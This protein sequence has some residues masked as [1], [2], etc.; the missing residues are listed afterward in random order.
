VLA[1]AEAINELGLL[2]RETPNA[3]VGIDGQ[4]E[5]VDSQGNCEGRLLAV[6]VKSGPSYLT[7]E[8]SDIVFTVNPK[9][10]GYWERFPLPVM[11][12][13][14]DPKEDRTYWVDARHALRANP[15]SKTI[16][17]P[18]ANHLETT[19]IH[20]LFKTAGPVTGGYL[21]IQE[22]AGYMASKRHPDSGFNISFLELFGLGLT[23]VGRQLFFSMAL[24]M[25]IAEHHA[26]GKN[27][28]VGVGAPEYQFLKDYIDFLAAQDLARLDYCAILIDWDTRELVP[29]FLEPLTH[30]GHALLGYLN[31]FEKAAE[32]C[33]YDSSLAIDEVG[34]L[35]LTERIINMATVHA[36]LVNGTP[37]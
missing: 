20:E 26:Q 17:V 6:Q 10:R 7:I 12:M 15:G 18:L 5:L 37:T 19:R 8:G 3:D 11:L 14:Y 35:R 13:I 2:W 4:V 1:V 9:H 30:R 33:F 32:P 22:L 16:R 27:V 23:N 36:K 28:G 24:V 31:D 25:D 29:A 21:S 34:R